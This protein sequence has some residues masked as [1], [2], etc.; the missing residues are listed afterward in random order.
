MGVHVAEILAAKH[1]SLWQVGETDEETLTAID[2]IGPV[3]AHSI[4][5]FFANPT[6]VKILKKLEKNG[7]NLK[8]L[9]EEEPSGEQPFEGKTFVFTGE[10]KTYGR[11]EAED[12][13]K[14]LGAKAAG[15]VSKLTT[16]VVAGEAAGSKLKKAKELGVEVLSEDEFE[17]MIKKYKK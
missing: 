14:K 12:L 10:L 9:K 15:S 13:V 6:N 8:R 17:K 1:K 3:V 4:G 2:G 11:K 16:Y 5:S 7:V